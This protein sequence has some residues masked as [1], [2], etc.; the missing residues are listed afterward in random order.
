MSVLSTDNLIIERGGSHYRVTASEVV[1]LFPVSDSLTSTS[2]TSALSA[3]Q[4]KNLKDLIDGLGDV[5]YHISIPARDASGPFNSGDVAFVNDDGDGKW[6]RY[7]SVSAGATGADV[8]WIK[9]ADQDALASGLGA[10]N[11]SY[12]PSSSNGLVTNTAGDDATIPIAD[13][14]NAGLLSPSDFLTLSRI[15]L[16]ESIDLDAIKLNLNQSKTKTDFLTVSS[17]IN[18]DVLSAASHDAVSLAGTSSS[19]PITISGQQ[20]GFDIGALDPAP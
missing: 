15:S 3:R 11:L 7:Q 6:A 1:S 12:T 16:T 4:G 8:T 5:T 19:N 20:L 13:T 18:L 10:T 14:T 17:N 9:I 2:S